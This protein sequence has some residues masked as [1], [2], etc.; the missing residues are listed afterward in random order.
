MCFIIVLP[1]IVHVFHNGTDRDAGLIEKVCG[2]IFRARFCGKSVAS[3]SS[4]VVV[5]ERRSEI[6][7]NDY[8]KLRTTI[9]P[10]NIV[11]SFS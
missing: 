5:Y 7:I 6:E 11:L 3:E 8:I 4:V 10:I 2:M 1:R 9:T